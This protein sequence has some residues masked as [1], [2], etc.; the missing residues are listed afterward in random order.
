MADFAGG[1]VASRRRIAIALVCATVAT[2]AGL[3]SCAQIDT[4][5]S[6]VASIA[7]DTLP[8]PAV[9]AHDSLRDSLGVARPLR[10]TA[11]NI[12]GA[13]LPATVIR[14]GTPDSGAKV[15]SISGYI[16]GDT[17]RSTLVRIIASTG[18]L[19]AAPDT[20]YVVPSPDT[21]LAV[22]ATDSLLYSLTD[23]TANVSN[24]LQ[25]QLL[26]RVPVSTPLPVRSWLVSYQIA[27][28]SDTTLAQL[29]DRNG[30]LRSRVDTTA[31]DGTSSR[32][33]RIR[34]LSLTSI[35]DSVVVIAT[36]R[37]RGAL[38]AGAPIRF[39]LQVKPHP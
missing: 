1:A 28:P 21:V 9:V 35:N 10:A 20:I 37:Y 2:V 23:T 13:T 12:E 15:D 29:V 16:V 4:D 32:R 31:A 18:R 5:P 33:I 3:V 17:A 24:P 8:F 6:H 34:P 36:V 25:L 26:H 38:V 27:Y 30:S 22:N 19:Q 11:Y 14:F 39:V 7:I